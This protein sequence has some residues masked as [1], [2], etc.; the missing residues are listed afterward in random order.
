MRLDSFLPAYDFREL[1]EVI[2]RAPASRI[3]R[4]IKVLKPAD[5]PV[6]ALLLAIRSLPGRVLGE[7]SMALAG[8]ISVL[9][10]FINAGFV[11]LAEER[12][13]RNSSGA[14][15]PVLENNRCRVAETR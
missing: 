10:Q 7:G 5:L 2:V 1:H 14:N 4:A 11:L 13:S 12:D 15:R 6:M 3:Y 9:E 8:E